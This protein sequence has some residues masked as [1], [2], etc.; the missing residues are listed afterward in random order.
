MK[1]ICIAVIAFI[2]MLSIT[3]C[4]TSFS[5]T[6][7]VSTGDSI[8]V[9]LDTS[10]GHELS[11]K[12]GEFFVSKDGVELTRGI[13]LTEEKYKSYFDN[14]EGAEGVSVLDSGKHNENEF[15]YY[16]YNDNGTDTWY[17]VISVEGS[18]TGVGLI[19]TS[20]QNSAK[21]IFELLSFNK[22]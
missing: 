7:N 5:Y 8:K 18:S 20:G 14:V 19:N 10:A 1:K 4:T 22:E 12:D 6:F 2:C 17:H 9:T 21:E 13:F 11:Q 3:A 16:L 15:I